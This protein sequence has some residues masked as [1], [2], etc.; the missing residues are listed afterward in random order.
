MVSFLSAKVR[1]VCS[2]RQ[3][4][5][6]T[7]CPSHPSGKQS[8]YLPIVIYLSALLKDPGS[9]GPINTSQK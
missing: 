7:D 6:T 5:R 3:E 2:V 1:K 8:S 4:N 9:F